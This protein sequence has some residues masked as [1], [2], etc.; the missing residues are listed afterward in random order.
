MRPVILFISILLL[1]SPLLGQLFNSPE[2][3]VFDEP[4][5]RYI[6]SN[7]ADSRL[8]IEQA[9][10]Q[11][12]YFGR[13]NA[14]SHGLAIIGDRLFSC[15]KNTI[16]IHDL[17]NDRLIGR[18]EVP[19]AVFFNGLCSDGNST[20]Y[21]TDFS[22]RRIYSFDFDGLNGLSHQELTSLT[23][24]PN[25]IPYDASNERLLLVTWGRNS[26]ILAYDFSEKE[27]TTLRKTAYDNLESILLDNDG[28][29]YMTGWVP[30][31]LLHYNESTDR[32]EE[33]SVTDVDRPTG[34][35]F[36]RNDELVLL[37]STGTKMRRAGIRAT[38]KNVDLS[39][40]VFPNPIVTNSL[41][42]YRLI[43]SG[44]VIVDLY[45]T[46]GRLVKHVSSARANKGEQQLLFDRRGL[47]EGMYF[48]NIKSPSGDQATPITLV[49]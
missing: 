21:A 35:S 48:L 34:L 37:G 38:S 36:G 30:S 22:K 19:S 49:D 42:T 15:L 2:S 47:P 44:N 26:S 33:L 14:G 27:L 43:E 18:Y 8:V 12:F 17:V 41:I 45:D 3:V 39:V 13:E 28:S 31:H 40:R 29:M 11:Q 1:S 9:D 23:Q 25:G 10:G 46:Q 20:L 24:I 7:A 16:L 6:V 4:R 5:D 32:I